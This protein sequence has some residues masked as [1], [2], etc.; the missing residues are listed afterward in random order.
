MSQRLSVTLTH[1][2]NSLNALHPEW[3]DLL[4]SSPA[5]SIFL[6]LEWLATWW[7][8]YQPGRQLWL[9]LARD[10]QSR[11]VGAAPLMLC[12]RSVGPLQ[13]R[14]LLFLSAEEG[15]GDPDHVDFLIASGW[16]EPVIR[17]FWDELASRHSEWDVLNLT[18]LRRDSP[19]L[20]YAPELGV[21]AIHE[22]G[23][24]CPYI[25]LPDSWETY[26][27]EALSRDHRKGIG[28]YGRRLEQ[29]M[30]ARSAYH[31][32]ASEIEIDQMVDTLIA[33]RRQYAYLNHLPDFFGTPQAVM[34]H[35]RLAK[36]LLE[37][38]W[39]HAYYLTIEGRMAA[40]VYDFKYKGV[41]YGYQTGYDPQWSHYSPGR[42]IIAYSIRKAIEQGLHK[43]DMLRGDEAYKVGW[44]K[45]LQTDVNL[46]VIASLQAQAKMRQLE[47]IR[48]LWKA[49]KVALPA[50]W[51]ARIRQATAKTG[52]LRT[53][54]PEEQP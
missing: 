32:V 44:A 26:A 16:T 49:V 31:E 12:R 45:Q 5:A 35:K 20:A 52:P 54:P 15:L 18:G 46:R 36:R 39:L 38:G 22:V 47:A 42:L 19:V 4:E 48:R 8:V 3:D 25:L 37:R 51:R 30:G 10:N 28:R 33:F 14:E 53:K 50:G 27:Q 24:A 40:W 29:E 9:L 41:A 1:N 7:E 21:E 6:T 43:Y 13:W 17:G 23:E 2:A 34:F 11:L